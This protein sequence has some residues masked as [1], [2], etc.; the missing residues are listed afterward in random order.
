MFALATSI[1]HCTTNVTRPKEKE[2]RKGGWKGGM[3]ERD[4]D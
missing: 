2:R 4:S 3:K 1:L